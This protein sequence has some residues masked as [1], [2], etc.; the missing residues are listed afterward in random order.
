MIGA[1]DVYLHFFGT[2]ESIPLEK[3]IIYLLAGIVIGF[4]SWNTM[5]GKYKN[6]LIDARV[7][8]SPSGALPPHDSP[9]QITADSESK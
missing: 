6:A 9:S 5:E 8:G 3:I 7:K 2:Q 4:D 1:T